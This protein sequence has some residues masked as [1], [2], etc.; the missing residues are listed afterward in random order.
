M[1]NMVNITHAN[2]NNEPNACNSQ[3]PM[4]SRAEAGV[5]GLGNRTYSAEDQH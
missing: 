1:L 2:P 3:R 5:R 4:V